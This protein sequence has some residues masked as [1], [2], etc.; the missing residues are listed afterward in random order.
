MIFLCGVEDLS[1]DFGKNHPNHL[2]KLHHWSGDQGLNT[3]CR[4]ADEGAQLQSRLTS[5]LAINLL[6]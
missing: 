6:D 1:G 2:L 5:L 4:I 3:N